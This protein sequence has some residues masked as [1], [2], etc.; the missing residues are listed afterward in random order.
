M[1]KSK[2]KRLA[3]NLALMSRNICG[4]INLV[5]K[6][7]GELLQT[8]FCKCEDNIKIDLKEIEREIVY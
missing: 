8:F 5:G 4:H 6:P 2:L 7:V 3:G 1:I